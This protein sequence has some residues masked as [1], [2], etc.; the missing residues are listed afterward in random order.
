M[1]TTAK[2]LGQNN[3]I[4]SGKKLAFAALYH[5]DFI[6][7]FVTTMIAMIAYNIEQKRLFFVRDCCVRTRVICG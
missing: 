1:T 2:P 7:Y 4:G 3:S 5:R 6:S